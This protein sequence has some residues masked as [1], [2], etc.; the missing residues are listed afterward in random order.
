[1]DALG[2]VYFDILVAALL[3]ISGLIAF[4]RGFVQEAL[5]LALWICAFIGAMLFSH[6]LSPYLVNLIENEELRKM[7]AV[8]STFIIIIFSGGFLIKLLRTMI[9]W[10][11]LG[12]LDRLLGIIFGFARGGILIVVLYLVIPE[13]L[14]QNSFVANSKSA[15]FLDEWAPRAESFFKSMI[16]NKN[17]VMLNANTISTPEN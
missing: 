13:E 11:G 17:S 7:I 1:L 15:V 2:L 16:S 14:K 9:H 6:Y 10:S 12:G 5:S 3:L 4:F 8:T